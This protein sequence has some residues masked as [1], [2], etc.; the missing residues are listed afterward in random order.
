MRVSRHLE[1]EFWS[2][3]THLKFEECVLACTPPTPVGV[4]V[5]VEN[6]WKKT[7]LPTELKIVTKIFYT[8]CFLT[9]LDRWNVYLI[10]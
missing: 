7:Q 4:G 3:T 8:K 5:H 10:Q 6:V 1:I 2:N 9:K